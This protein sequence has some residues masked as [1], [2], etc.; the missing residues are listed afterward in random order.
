MALAPLNKNRRVQG[1]KY[2]AQPGT[3]RA[4]HQYGNPGPKTSRRPTSPLL[5]AKASAFFTRSPWSDALSVASREIISDWWLVHEWY[6]LF[7]AGFPYVT[8]ELESRFLNELKKRHEEDRRFD[9]SRF[10]IMASERLYEEIWI[11]D[12]S[13]GPESWV[14]VEKAA[15]PFHLRLA[16]V[17]EYTPKIDS[18]ALYKSHAHIDGILTLETTNDD[19]GLPSNDLMGRELVERW[20]AGPGREKAWRTAPRLRLANKDR[21]RLLRCSQQR[22]GTFSSCSTFLRNPEFI[23]LIKQASISSSVPMVMFEH[24]M[25]YQNGTQI[26]PKPSVLKNALKRLGISTSNKSW[27]RTRSK[28]FPPGAVKF[29]DGDSVDGGDGEDNEEDDDDSFEPGPPHGYFEG[30]RISDMRDDM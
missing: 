11:P 28:P 9:D 14:K 25:A 13:W 19:T 30:D 12:G 4:I 2:R 10:D 16:K 18:V 23:S 29:V 6:Y 7:I 15:R 3:D 26:Y 20:K 22:E 1:S 5:P 24:G 27:P 17:F 8:G 21:T